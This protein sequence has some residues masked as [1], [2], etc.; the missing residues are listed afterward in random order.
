MDAGTHVHYSIITLF[1]APMLCR[2]F[3]LVNIGTH[4][5]WHMGSRGMA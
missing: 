3:N 2:L 1:I 5:M 4:F